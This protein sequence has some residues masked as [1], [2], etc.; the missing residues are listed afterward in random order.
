M[1]KKNS[2]KAFSNPVDGLLLGGTMTDAKFLIPAVLYLRLL[3]EHR[4]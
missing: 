4:Q 1:R 3:T 2:A